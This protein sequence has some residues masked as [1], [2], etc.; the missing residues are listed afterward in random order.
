MKKVLKFAA[1]II[2]LVVLGLTFWFYDSIIIMTKNKNISGKVDRIPTIASKELPPITKTELDWTNWL[3]ADL[4]NTALVE[5]FPIEWKSGLKKLW[6]VSYLCQDETTA[7]WSAPVIK[8]NRLILGGRDEDNVILFCLNPENGKL[9]WKNSY[10]S[11]ARSSYGSGCRATPWI[12]EDKIYTF[13]RSG[14]LVCWNLL[15]GKLLWSKNVKDEGGEEPKWG[16]SCSPFVYNSMVIVNAGG[17]ARTIAFDISSGEVKWKTG[18]APAGYAAISMMTIDGTPVILDF[19]G[20]GLAA[21]NAETGK[22]LWN[23]PWKTSYKVNATTPV[24]KD[25]LIFITSGYKTGGTL[26]KASKDKIETVWKNKSIASHH[27]DPFILGDYIYGYTGYSMQNKGE[28]KCLDIK[29]GEEKWATGK[30]G[31]GTCIK[32]NE[33]LLCMDIKG[34]LFL[35]KPNPDK[36]EILTSI[37]NVLGEVQGA[38]WTKPIVAQNK[39]FIRFKQRLL[40]FSLKN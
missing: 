35:L 16:Y 28:F 40:C 24:F 1:V 26:L 9:I 8:G 34:N 38:A 18:G 29:T 31:W 21:M 4:S 33:N 6:E 3:R 2:I 14:D 11:K 13:G 27:S 30:L 15:D 22:E 37:S 20:V 23:I 17:S 25:N 10:A 36:P 32:V 19:H 5:N 7:V 39:L 12:T